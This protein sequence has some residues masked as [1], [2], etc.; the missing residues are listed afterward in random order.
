MIGPYIANGPSVTALIAVAIALSAVGERTYLFETIE[1]DDPDYPMLNSQRFYFFA[2]AH[3]EGE[4]MKDSGY[5]KSVTL[6]GMAMDGE[7]KNQ[8]EVINRRV[9]IARIADDLMKAFN[10]SP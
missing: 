9:G 3:G 8:H 4:S 10:I 5:Y 6:I 2:N 7:W 1:T